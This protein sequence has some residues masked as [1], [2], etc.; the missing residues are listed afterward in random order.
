MF[1]QPGLPTAVRLDAEHLIVLDR[2][3]AKLATKVHYEA[4][5]ADKSELRFENIESLIAFN[6]PKVRAIRSLR[7]WAS[8]RFSGR[9]VSIRITDDTIIYKPV[10]LTIEAPDSKAN[11]FKRAFEAWLADAAQP[12]L[13]GL[14]ARQSAWSLGMFGVAALVAFVLGK[15]VIRSMLQGDF[16]LR[17]H[18]DNTE[19]S[20]LGVVLAYGIFLIPVAFAFVANAFRKRFYPVAVFAIGQGQRRFEELAS[21]RN[22]WVLCILIP[23]V[24]GVIFWRL[25]A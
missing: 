20:A 4:E 23:F 15:A 24:M 2:E 11:E 12:R 1:H 19:L 22:T 18:S 25:A 9:V 17:V 13:Y 10:T 3:I 14:F 16:S 5:L 21:S 8:N 6:N 7:V